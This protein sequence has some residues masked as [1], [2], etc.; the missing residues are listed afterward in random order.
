MRDD[1]TTSDRKL[2]LEMF[3]KFGIKELNKGG[4]AGR[5]Q[6]TINLFGDASIDK[7]RRIPAKVL[8]ALPAPEDDG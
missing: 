5:A 1:A 4:T 2:A 8:D 7:V 6:L 3:E